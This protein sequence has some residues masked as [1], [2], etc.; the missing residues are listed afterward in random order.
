[1]CRVYLA[2]DTN[3][4]H[5]EADRAF[6]SDNGHLTLQSGKLRVVAG[7]APGSWTHWHFVEMGERA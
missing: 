6:V 4:I 3:I 5:I 7:F 2:N 1:M